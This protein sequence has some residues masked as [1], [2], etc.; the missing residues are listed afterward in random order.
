MRVS[1][2]LLLTFLVTSLLLATPANAQKQMAQ[3]QKISSAKTVYFQNET[4]SDAVGKNAEAQIKK[5]GKYQLV[6][7]PKQADLI[8]LLSADAYNGGNIIFASGQTGSVDKGGINVDPV[9]D[10]NK[11]APTRFAF[12]TV[13]DP[14]TGENLWS[15]R[16]QWGGL[17]TGF[18]SV[19]ER[20]VKKL[21][22]QTKK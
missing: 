14:K 6:A 22:N 5:W 1:E 4:A 12:L 8:F 20:L 19:G 13:I 16:H 3:A 21:E 11:Q 17:L 7:N 9:P 2:Y 18:N 10:Y 15:D